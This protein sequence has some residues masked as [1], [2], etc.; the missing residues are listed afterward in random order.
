[1]TALA[2]R[3]LAL[4]LP[5]LAGLALWALALRIGQ[6]GLTP[7]RIFAALAAALALGYGLAYGAAAL[8]GAWAA[9]IRRANPWLAL[10][11][12]ALAAL[13][14]TPLLNPERLS[15]AA[16]IARLTGGAAAAGEVDLW[17]M[18]N[19]WG[20]AGEA[21]IER[22]RASDGAPQV[23]AALA[24]LD[25]AP[26]RFGYDTARR[27]P[28]LTT[29]ADLA[30]LL[31]VLPLGASLPA[32][33]LEGRDPVDL[34]SWRAACERVTPAGNPGCA[35]VVADLLPASPGE[36]GVLLWQATPDTVMAE[37]LGTAPG[38]ARL[39]EAG[40]ALHADDRLSPAD[41]DALFAEGPRLAPVTLPGLVLGGRA[42]VAL[43]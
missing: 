4:A 12:L 24:R 41:L 3:A 18:A 27:L 26:D 30:A 11:A 21:G 15:T 28:D 13:W 8:S 36:E 32:A 40:T 2:A 37:V 7:D 38:I 5:V 23:D 19:M 17:P 39:A 35:L 1:M 20:R 9:G 6:Y 16:Q 33:L 10:A 31:P 29:P 42:L 25:A 34:D 14:C 22:L 43:P